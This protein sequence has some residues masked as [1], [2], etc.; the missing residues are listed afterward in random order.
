M[1]HTNNTNQYKWISYLFAF[2]TLNYA[3]YVLN[4][5]KK[6]GIGEEIGL[7][8]IPFS[9]SKEWPCPITTHSNEVTPTR[10]NK[11]IQILIHTQL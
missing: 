2:G 1:T 7:V 8:L 5:R 10:I 6:R 3:Y 4:W 11:F 9:S